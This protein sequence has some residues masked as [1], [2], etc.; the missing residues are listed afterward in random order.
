[1]GSFS[2]APSDV[3]AR[4][5]RVRVAIEYGKRMLDLDIPRSRL[6]GIAQPKQ[7]E[8][9]KDVRD[10]VERS[11]I[12]PIGGPPLRGILSGA[13]SAVILTVNH[14][15]PSPRALLLPILREC[16]R[17]GV[18]ATLCI[19]GGR[20]RPMTRA[21]L[22]RH[23]GK[24]IVREYRVVQHD[25]FDRKACW[26]LGR[27]KRGTEVLVNRILFEHD[28]VIG[29]GIIEPSYLA[30]WSGGRKLLMPGVAF[31]ESIDNNHFYLT[32]PGTRIGRLRGNPLSEDAEEFARAC[33]FHFI[34]YAISGPNDE[35]VGV[36]A[37]DPYRAHEVACRRCAPI[38]R[39]RA[40]RAPIVISSAGGHPYDRDLVQGKKA[41]IPAIDLVERNGVIVLLAACPDGLGA[42]KT[43][44]EWLGCKT[45]AEVVR[46]VRRRELFSLGAHGANILARPIV[47]KNATVI[48]VTRREVARA[49]AGTYIRAVSRFEE[50][51]HLV[52]VLC[53]RSA[54]V[55]LLRKARRLIT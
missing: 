40:K 33:P 36:V 15:R 19:A 22:R 34:C 16:G 3:P 55:L 21:E 51:W 39:V 52:S 4:S 17:Q 29:T 11:L 46:D 50:A 45:P 43:F 26:H 13:R 49:L 37:G 12:R 18:R 25:P 32:A 28:R 10:A 53:G 44:I 30:G 47:E 7:V 42:E 41:I 14:T 27:T 9:V 23:L 31:H 2:F 54:G 38:Y 20:H 24:S 48:L 6:R 35:V 1:M 8:P 5:D